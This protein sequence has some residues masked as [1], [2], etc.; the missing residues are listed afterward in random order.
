MRNTLFEALCRKTAVEV[1]P[2]AGFFGDA[3][4][5]A[6][7]DIS[8]GPAL[9][10]TAALFPFSGFAGNT[11]VITEVDSPFA[12]AEIA[13]RLM[14]FYGGEEEVYVINPSR[15]EKVKIADLQSREGWDYA[16]CIVAD[17]P[18]LLKKQGYNFADLVGI[19]ARLRGEGGCPWDREQT[20]KSL[21][22]NMIEEA[23]EAVDAIDQGDPYMLEDELGDVLMQ[24]ALHADIASEHSDFDIDGVTTAVCKKL[25]YRHPH[26]FGDVEVKNSAEVLSN[27]EELKKKEK[28]LASTAD[29]MRDI[30]KATSA[31]IR[32]AKLHKKAANV[33]FDWA[34]YTGALE[35]VLEEAG[36]LKEAAEQKGNVEEEAGD[37]LLACVNLLC[38]LKINGE[39]ALSA[40]CAKFIGRFERMEQA[41]AA[42]GKELKD[43]DME[44]KEALW[45]E[46]KY[47]N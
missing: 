4:S 13:C 29:S 46:N 21:R 2:G 27:W 3:L 22:E 16:H 8:K 7:K 12:A 28:H 36:E 14:R 19:I 1:T 20:H 43:M 39:V 5:L 25:I 30:P 44:E 15:A 6:A 34:D 26:I 23:Y 9:V 17:K 45:Q 18:D 11:A 32:A 40:A 24:V 38:K 42:L 47:K 35:K 41:A 37:L 33:G 31:L 10:S